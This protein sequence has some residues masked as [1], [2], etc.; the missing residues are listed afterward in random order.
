MTTV[1]TT[2]ALLNSRLGEPSAMEMDSVPGATIMMYKL[3]WDCGCK[4]E[5]TSS[6]Y[7][8]RPC[9]AHVSTFTLTG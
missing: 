9:A 1:R 8:C 2:S 7:I 4:A 6:D 3:K 5:G